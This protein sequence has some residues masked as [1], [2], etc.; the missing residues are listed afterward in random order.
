MPRGQ[1]LYIE[2]LDTSIPESIKENSETAVEDPEPEISPLKRQQKAVE[3]LQRL[4]EHGGIMP[5][6]DP[7][8]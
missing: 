8:E 4:A 1:R 2:F 3:I 6:I 7:L 5:G